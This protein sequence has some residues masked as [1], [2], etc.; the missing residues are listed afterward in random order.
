MQK[1]YFFL[2]IAIALVSYFSAPTIAQVW[3]ESSDGLAPPQMEGGNTELE[4]ADVNRDGNVDLLCIGDHGS[5]YINTNEHGVM[6]W[7]GDGAGNWLI[8][9]NGNFGYGGIAVG[10]VNNDGFDDVGYGMHHNYSGED[11]G[12]QLI[13]VAL[14]DG[15]GLNW[16][17]YDDGLATNGETWGMFG[18]DFADIDADGLLDLVSVSF[19]SGSGIHVYRNNGDGSWTQSYGYNGGNSGLYVEFGDMNGDGYPDIASTN[20]DSGIFIN[21][22]AGDYDVL[23]GGGITPPSYYG[24]EDI[25]LGDVDND[26]R[27]DVAIVTPGG[28]VEAWKLNED[29]YTWTDLTHGLNAYPNIRMVDIA[30]MDGDGLL[31]IIGYGDGNVGIFV[32]D[33][34][35]S[36]TLLYGFTTP[37]P[38]SAKAFR[39]GAD[40]D[41]N[42][43]G[44]IALVNEEGGWPNERNHCRAYREISTPAELTIVNEYPHGN[45]VIRGGSAGWVEWMSAVPGEQ[46]TE[47]DIEFSSTGPDGPFSGLASGLPNNGKHQ[48]HWPMVNSANCYLRLTV[49]GDTDVS[50]ITPAAFEIRSEISSDL[51]IDIIPDNPPI[52]V[53]QGGSFSYTGILTNNTNQSQTAD[54]WLMLNVPGIGEYGPISRYN[55]VSLSAGE[56]ITLEGIT[57][58]VPNYAPLG[59]YDYI[60]RCGDYPST[61][62]DQESFMFT[63]VAPSRGEIDSWELT[64]WFGSENELTPSVIRIHGAYPN[65]FNAHTSIK[66]EIPNDAQVS[67]TMYNLIGQ[68]IDRLTNG[69]LH[70]GEHSIEWDASNYSSGIYFYKLEIEDKIFTRRMTL[71]K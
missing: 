52:T 51:S 17:P 47:V 27:D 15:T 11:F 23:I 59:E 49:H 58:F 68:R 40:I 36:W 69:W 19:G 5:P 66:F 39:A 57:Q 22:G 9:Q 42:G 71:V 13:E 30:D 55:N 48:L 28:R 65:P 33:G 50:A 25:A 61:I 8:Y 10:D 35:S 54:V 37:N 34:G 32:G 16:T 43:Y 44:D 1:L 63:V 29:G 12:D 67:L 41:N 38:G 70:T 18:S 7:F 45:E 3:E 53:P 56:T 4:F 64:G 2:L 46:S 60:A 24:Y 31:D 21:D 14:G 6:V 62:I 20:G 26:G